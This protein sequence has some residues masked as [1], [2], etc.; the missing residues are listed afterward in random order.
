MD[1]TK[2]THPKIRK[3]ECIKEMQNIIEMIGPHAVPRNQMVKRYFFD[4]HT[5]DKWLNSL[6]GAVPKEQIDFIGSKAEQA[7]DKAI[8]DCTMIIATPGLK[9]SDK[10]GALSTLNQILKTQVELLEAYGRKA[11]V[12]ERLNVSGNLPAIFNLVEKSVEEIKSD[13]S[14][15]KPQAE[16]NSKSA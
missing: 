6:I 13:K 9:P 12:E 16:G 3:A 2:D 8:R 1:I 11:K 7:I 4:W 14:G 15:D 5:I 10:T